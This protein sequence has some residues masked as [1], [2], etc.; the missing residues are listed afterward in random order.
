MTAGLRPGYVIQ[1]VDRIPVEQIVEEAE[2]VLPPPHNSRSRIART[3]K[4]IL[5][6]VYG[7]P[8]TEVTIAYTDEEGEN[9]EKT[10]MRAKRDG[11]AVGPNGRFFMAVES[12]ARRLDN[13]I[14][15]VRLNT[16]QP[17]LAARVSGAINSMG[18]L[19][20]IVF[21]LRGNSGGEIERTP[22]LFLAERTWLYTRKTRN[23]ETKVFVDPA[24][25][26]FSQ[27]TL[28]LRASA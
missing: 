20:G 27:T 5:G 23:G 7:A 16:L 10:I 1:A 9:G 12:E 25:V 17:E 28:R 24:A 19:P 4:A 21:D 26:A 15:Y 18:D 14:G 11:V 2:R 8:G 22:E 13:G 3:A 6:R